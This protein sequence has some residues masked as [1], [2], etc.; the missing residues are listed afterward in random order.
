M[1]ADPM[2][3]WLWAAAAIAMA[4]AGPLLFGGMD[5]WLAA[6]GLFPRSTGVGAGAMPALSNRNIHGS[7]GHV[8]LMHSVSRAMRWR[9]PLMP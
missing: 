8:R 4:F 1:G 3:R 5:T 9:V 7:I 2:T 6:Q